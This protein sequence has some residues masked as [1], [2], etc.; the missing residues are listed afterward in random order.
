[1][2]K[3]GIVTLSGLFLA[4]LFFTLGFFFARNYLGCSVLISRVPAAE[5][6]YAE[7]IPVSTKSDSA[8]PININTASAEELTILPGI[9][10]VLAQRIV[11]YR[12]KNG[13]FHKIEELMDV[14]GI[15]QSRMDNLRPYVTIGGT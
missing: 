10:E 5:P 15:G 11:D 13:A 3:S 7:S 9:G 12:T 14:E 1:M 2:K 8:F 4:F 6:S